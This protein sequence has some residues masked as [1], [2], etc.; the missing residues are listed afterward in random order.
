MDGRRGADRRVVPCLFAHPRIAF[1]WL[2]FM[3][4]FVLLRLPWKLILA[5][6]GAVAV[7]AVAFLL[8][9]M[10][11]YQSDRY[12]DPSSW[13][14]TFVP[15]RTVPEALRAHLRAEPH[16]AGGAAR[17]CDREPDGRCRGGDGRG[18]ADGRSG[19]R[20]G[21]GATAMV[22]GRSGVDGVRWFRWWSR[23]RSR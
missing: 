1:T 13:F 20:G 4:P 16:C 9:M 2:L 12:F 8:Y 21:D 7:C 23:Q 5:M 22:C 19:G 18:R 14:H 11:S 3:G 17:V 15:N 6:V 10:S